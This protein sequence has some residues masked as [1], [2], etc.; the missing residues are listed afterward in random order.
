MLVLRFFDTLQGS[1]ETE[2]RIDGEKNDLD[3]LLRVKGPEFFQKHGANILLGLL[4][5]AAIVYFFLQKRTANELK[6][7]EVN[8]NTSVAFNDAMFLRE[9]AAQGDLSLQAGERRQRIAVNAIQ[10]ADNVLASDSDI[11]Q[12]ASAQLA[13]AEVYWAL[14]TTPAQAFAATQP[15]AGFAQQKPQEYLAKAREAY[16]QVLQQYPDQKE[17]AANAL[18]SLAAVC[19]TERKFPEA[20]DWYQ[21]VLRDDTLRSVYH[22]IARSRVTMLE[23]LQRPIT[24]APPT[25]LPSIMTPATAPSTPLLLVPPAT[26]APAT[27]P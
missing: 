13:K 7:L 1:M 3:V 5:V 6:A 8:S 17:I 20:N 24:L 9:S 25:S 27:Q 11:A 12:K 4:L 22:D 23:D 2:R 18:L 15:V 21:K 16:V 26:T 19:E 10:A 14:A